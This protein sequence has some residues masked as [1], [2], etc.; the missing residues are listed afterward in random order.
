MTIYKYQFEVQDE[1]E[2]MMPADSEVLC[3]Q[4]QRNSPCIWA[5]VDPNVALR[6]KHFRVFGTGQQFEPPIGR[7]IGTFQMGGGALVFHLFEV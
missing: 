6:R 5:I 3:V 4:M 2:I 1:I 7:Y